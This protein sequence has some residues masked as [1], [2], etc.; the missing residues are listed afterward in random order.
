MDMSFHA[1][2]SAR[3]EQGLDVIPLGMQRKPTQEF[4]Q[5]TFI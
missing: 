1:V 4:E 5:S 2:S 3:S